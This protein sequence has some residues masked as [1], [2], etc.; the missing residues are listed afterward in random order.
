MAGI[1][2]NSAKSSDDDGEEKKTRKS[3]G[4]LAPS[5]EMKKREMIRAWM[6]SDDDASPRRERVRPDEVKQG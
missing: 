5:L 4:R 6:V 2:I 3:A 1:E